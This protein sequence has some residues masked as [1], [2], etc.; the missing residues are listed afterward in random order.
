MTQLGIKII[1]P[2]TNR[3][4]IVELEVSKNKNNKNI[5]KLAQLI[6]SL[7]NGSINLY[8][9]YCILKNF[10][11]GKTNFESVEIKGFSTQEKFQ[12]VTNELIGLLREHGAENSN[13]T[14]NTTFTQPFTFSIKINISEKN[15]RALI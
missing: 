12:V 2:E 15:V 8:D 5:I 11:N 3:N 7:G 13:I 6:S 9:E 14:Y 1:G 10:L 4:D